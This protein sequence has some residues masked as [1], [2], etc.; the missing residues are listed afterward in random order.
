MKPS[1]SAIVFVCFLLTRAALA[2]ITISPAPSATARPITLF[3]LRAIDEQTQKDVPT[4]FEVL[5]RGAKKTYRG[6][7]NAENSTF[8]VKIEDSD[9]VTVISSAEG[10]YTI[11][12]DL[13]ISCDTCG[14]YGY[15]ALMERRVPVPVVSHTAR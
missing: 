13:V 15:V 7:T 10:Y 1:V 3:T 2:Q 14:F 4:A 8:S 12:E 5:L 9:T 11:E 6:S